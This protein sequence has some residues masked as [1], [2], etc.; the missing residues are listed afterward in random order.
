MEDSPKPRN[1]YIDDESYEWLRR[2]AAA[3]G[4]TISLVIRDCIQAARN[5]VEHEGAKK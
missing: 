3:A 2:Q 1:V 4:V 5:L